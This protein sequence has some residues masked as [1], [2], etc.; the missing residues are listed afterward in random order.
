[1]TQIA[2]ITKAPGSKDLLKAL[3]SQIM[4]SPISVTFHLDK[5]A[6]ALPE[7]TTGDKLM[8]ELSNEQGGI[9][10]FVFGLKL[11]NKIMEGWDFEIQLVKEPGVRFT[12]TFSGKYRKGSIVLKKN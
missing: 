3:E 11:V 6:P 5:L 9:E 1:M 12:G 4:G 10:V 2:H 8:I 7:S